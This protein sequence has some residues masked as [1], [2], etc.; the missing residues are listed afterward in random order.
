MKKKIYTLAASLAMTALIFAGFIPGAQAAVSVTAQPISLVSS[1]ITLSASSAQTGLFSFSLSAS[2]G[3]TLS[4]VSIQVNAANASTTVSGSHI[5][6][7]NL[8]QDNGNN[9]FNPATDVLVGSQSS[10]NIGSPTIITPTASTSVGGEFY[11]SLATSANWS[12]GSPADS[13]TV[14]LPGNAILTS[15][16][17]PSTNAVT[18]AAISAP[19]SSINVTVV[20]Y[21]NGVPATANSANNYSFSMNISQDGS[22][23][24]FSL[25]PT[26]TNT[27]NPYQIVTALP[28]G[29]NSYSGYENIFGSVGSSCSSGLPYA[30]TGYTYSATSLADAASL[31]PTL[32]A[33]SFSNLT[34]NEYVIVW[35]STCGG[36]TPVTTPTS[37]SVSIATQLSSSSVATGTPVY[38]AAVLSNATASASG[39]VT[40]NVYNNSAYRNRYQNICSGTP[41]FTSTQTVTDGVVPVS[42]SFTP[43][44]AGTYNWQAVY[45]GDANNNGAASACGSEVLTVSSTQSTGTSGTS[46]C[47]DG[48]IN[49]RIYDLAGSDNYYTAENCALQTLFNGKI[50][51]HGRKNQFKGIITKK[52]VKGLV[53]PPTPPT[54]PTPPGPQNRDQNKGPNK[55]VKGPG[56]PPTPPT[57]QDNNANWNRGGNQGSNQNTN[58]MNTSA[59]SHSGFSFGKIDFGKL[60]HFSF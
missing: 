9:S 14:T 38:D 18:T 30:L 53:K 41:V 35:N 36:S 52:S 2:A 40:Y 47:S 13:I 59:N 49:G 56:N 4:G 32:T 6:S 50:N 55:P 7:V 8:Y 43:A 37:S 5:A 42:G 25:G 28:S 33:P 23:G 44:A 45:S 54:P 21:L 31:A 16:N 19:V 22:D 29:G 11:V 3:E 27:A 34:S 17:S 24:N 58:N 51:F 26:G 20:K 57:P 12:S 15:A 10:V 39:T 1:P 60:P 46:V 48:L